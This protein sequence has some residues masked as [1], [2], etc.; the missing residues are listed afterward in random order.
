VDALVRG[1]VQDL[2]Y[3]TRHR[4]DVAAKRAAG[5]YGKPGKVSAACPAV[6]E[7]YQSIYESRQGASPQPKRPR[8]PR[9]AKGE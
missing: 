8:R 2:V 7:A 4:D 1:V 3:D 5:E 6:V 9:K